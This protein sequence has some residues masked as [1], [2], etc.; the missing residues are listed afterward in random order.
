MTAILSILAVIGT[1]IWFYLTAERQRLPAIAWALA[2]VLV[3]YAGFSFWMYVILRPLMGSHFQSHGFGTGIAM[4][5]SSIAF[6]ALA[7]T[8]FRFRVLLK[9]QGPAGPLG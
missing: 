5:L 2:G 8:L 4:D 7:M 3:Y 6:G 1:A 9:K